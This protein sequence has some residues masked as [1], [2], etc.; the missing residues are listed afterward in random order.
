MTPIDPSTVVP[1][2]APFWFV[3]FFKTLGFVLHLV[4]MHIWLAGIPIALFFFLCGGPNAKTCSRRFF[5]QL[6]FFMAFGINLGIVPLLFVQVGY[7]WAFYPATIL[8]AWHWFSVIPLTLLAYALVYLTVS[9]VKKGGRWAPLLT[10]MVASLALA[11]VGLIFTANWTLMTDTASWHEIWEKSS[12]ASA[13]TGLGTAWNKTV[14]IRFSQT[15]ALSLLTFS[16]WVLFDAFFFYKQE[17]SD[18]KSDDVSSGVSVKQ[19]SEPVTKYYERLEDNPEFKKLPQNK[20]DDLL[21]KQKRGQLSRDEKEQ[22]LTYTEME[23]I[24]E[25]EYEEIA[26]ESADSEFPVA[27]NYPEWMRRFALC[28]QWFGLFIAAGL[29][30][31]YYFKELPLDTETM[32]PVLQTGVRHLLTAVLVSLGIFTLVSIFA[33][34]GKLRGR[35]LACALFGA[36]LLVISLWSIARQVIQNAQLKNYLDVSMIPQQ[37]EWSPLIIF[38]ITFVLG[39]GVVGYL[40]NKAIQA[41]T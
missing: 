4:P 33:L 26:E 28:L 3:S 24:I 39:A 18:E 38:L 37:V 6:P 12:V 36:D 20:R 13:V 9:H 1:I 30:W 35:S 2:P 21:R 23:E 34:F 7:P 25:E 22:Y 29:L 31:Y 27:E 10:G 8:T 16:C 15:F 19:K 11:A 5:C 14:F 17:Q 41:N 32:A 40:V